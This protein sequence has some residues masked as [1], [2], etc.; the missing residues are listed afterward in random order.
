MVLKFSI[1][2]QFFIVKLFNKSLLLRILKRDNQLHLFR[3]L[4]KCSIR[5][6]KWE[7][8]I[9]FL[10]LCQNFN[11]TPTIAKLNETKL[12]KWK[13]SADNFQKQVISEELKSKL[14]QLKTLR[15]ELRNIHDEVRSNCS[16]ISAALPQYGHCHRYKRVSFN[17]W[18]R[19]MLK[20]CLAWSTR[21]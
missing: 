3:R 9:E 7:G 4:E 20:N 14:V 1:L 12:R 8:A 2:S 15:E 16:T 11:L 17:P 13:K 5:H 19:L 10:R 18:W 21:K 6:T